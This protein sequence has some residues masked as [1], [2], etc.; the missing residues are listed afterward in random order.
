MNGGIKSPVLIV[1]NWQK[2]LCCRMETGVGG[3][4]HNTAGSQYARLD[5]GAVTEQ[6]RH[7]CPVS[8]EPR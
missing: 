3:A 8:A 5:C 4:R 6:A 1:E 2:Y 7:W